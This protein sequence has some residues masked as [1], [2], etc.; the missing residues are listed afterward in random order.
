VPG[1]P[2]GAMIIWTLAGCGIFAR[3]LLAIG[4]DKH[5]DTSVTA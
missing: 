2:S 5:L 1:L 3:M 4:Q